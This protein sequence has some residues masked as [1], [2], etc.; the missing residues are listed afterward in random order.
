MPS[1]S[2]FLGLTIAIRP[3]V[4]QDLQRTQAIVLASVMIVIII[5]GSR[6][7]WANRL[8][9]VQAMQD[10]LTGL[11]NRR[12]FDETIEQEYRRAART[13]RP[14][15]VI[16]IDVD[17]FKDYNDCYG[18]LV[19]DQCLCSIART[20][21]GC[22]RR[23]GDFAARYGGEEIVVVLP[24]TDAAHA[25]ILAETMRLAVRRLALQHARDVHGVVTFSAGVATCILGQNSDG[26]QT[27][28]GDADA[29]L[30]T[31]KARGRD[32]VEVC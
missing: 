17:H 28:V 14:V 3:Y 27:L 29:A 22:L 2:W 9:R 10:G 4:R 11:A 20:I 7:V 18:H 1:L 8:L 30:Y 12:Y 13:R 6:V 19:G 24:G 26:W 21:K 32:T 31:A 23:A 25:T 5:S 15:S 16:M